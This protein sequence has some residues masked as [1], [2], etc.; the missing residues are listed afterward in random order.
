MLVEASILSTGE[1][2]R[3]VSM[4]FKCCCISGIVL[5]NR[6]GEREQCLRRSMVKNGVCVV[7]NV[8]ERVEKSVERTRNK[9][10]KWQ[11]G[12]WE[13]GFGTVGGGPF[14]GASSSLRRLERGE[15]K[16]ALR[17]D[18]LPIHFQVWLEEGAETMCLPV[19]VCCCLLYRESDMSET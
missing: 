11:L 2:E 16:A 19:T 17:H 8:R 1:S 18:V 4:A 13:R 9:S 15:V 10:R 5:V 14:K 6:G 3:G 12:E 7:V